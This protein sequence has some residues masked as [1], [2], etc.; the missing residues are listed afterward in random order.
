MTTTTAKAIVT[1]LVESEDNTQVTVY[2]GADYGT[3]SDPI[4]QEWAAYTPALSLVMGVKPSV[5]EHFP[6][7]GKFT[8]TFELDEPAA[9]APAADPTPAPQI[10]TSTTSAGTEATAAASSS[11]T[12]AAVPAAP[13]GAAETTPPAP[14]TEAPSSASASDAPPAQDPLA[15]A[16][17]TVDHNPAASTSESGQ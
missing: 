1:N 6:I 17:N 16:P 12:P 8:L 7:G 11:A 14:A 3:D 13:A 5:A 15:V 2:L 9:E 4:N 10:P